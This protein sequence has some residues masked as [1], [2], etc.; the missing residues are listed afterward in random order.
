MGVI[1]NQSLKSTIF[2]YIGVILGFVTVGILMPKFLTP[3]EIGVR[4]QIQ[5]YA[6]VISSVIALGI[7]QSIIRMFPHFKNEG[8]KNHGILSLSVLITGVSAVIFYFI[9]EL[10]STDFLKSDIINSPIFGEYFPL[11]L[12]FTIATLFYNV[13]D[14]YATANKESTIGVFLK[15]IVLRGFI[16]L[17]LILFVF[18]DQIHFSQLIQ[19]IT[20][21]QFIPLI[22][23]LIFLSRKSALL[24]PSSIS[25]PS[26]KLRSD[27]VSVS[28]FG[29][30]N[31]LSAVAIVSI[32]SIMLS[33]L[34]D[35]AA[36][37]IY[38]TVFFFA[39]LILIPFKSLGKITNSVVAEYFKNG[40][41]EAISVLY[42]KSSFNPLIIGLFLLGN[43]TLVLPFI[44]N[45]L[46]V[47][48]SEGT[49]VM[50]YIGLANLITMSSG[51]TFIILVNSPYFRWS[52]IFL[53]GFMILL[54]LTNFVLIPIMGM[55]GAAIAS[56]ISN[57]IYQFVGLFF[58]KTKLHFWPFDKKFIRLLTITLGLWLIIFLVP[59]M[60]YP[61]I[62]SILKS[63]LFSVI[64]IGYILKYN[65][66]PDLNNQAKNFLSWKSK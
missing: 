27:Y 46:L 65:I 37:G 11:I 63:G 51:A 48:Y 25:F 54:V 1:F 2:S 17:A 29:W 38:T 53:V 31:G 26:K 19:A 66:S 4:M 41:M 14:N 15:D 45:V 52:T 24:V 60:G 13:L 59:D 40:D 44:F 57:A 7:P 22:L 33:K 64:F 21:V 10:F 30:I 5:S 62:I 61:V 28:L 3:E 34:I 12:P 8:N 50:I 42:K 56:L 36:V 9:F 23:I 18:L 49:N 32:D 43:L 39:T 58:V 35:S 16:L 47:G 55:T 6:L 20:Y